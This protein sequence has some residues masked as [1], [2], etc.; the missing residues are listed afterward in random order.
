MKDFRTLVVWQKAHALTLAAQRA[1]EA[2]PRNEIYGLT[3]EIQ[4]AAAAVPASIAE[5]CGVEGADNIAECL[6]I[7]LNSAS[8]LEYQLRRARNLD[9]IPA[10]LYTQLDAD[11]KEVERMLASLVEKLKQR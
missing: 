5:C 9:F 1:A 8:E 4:R 10:S 6:Q 11:T 3:S 2:F 7:A